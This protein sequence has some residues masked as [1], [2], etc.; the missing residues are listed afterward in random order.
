[1]K[2]SLRNILLSLVMHPCETGQGAGHSSAAAEPEEL[3]W[4]ITPEISHAFHKLIL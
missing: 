3:W 2:S 1:M 4:F